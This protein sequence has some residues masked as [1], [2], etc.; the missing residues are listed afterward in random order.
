M[1]RLRKINGIWWYG[2]WYY[3]KK[4]NDWRNSNT[5]EVVPNARGKLMPLI[6]RKLFVEK[7]YE[8]VYSGDKAYLPRKVLTYPKPKPKRLSY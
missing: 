3:R 8:N 5:N 1:A 6:N 4:T 2:Q 7:P